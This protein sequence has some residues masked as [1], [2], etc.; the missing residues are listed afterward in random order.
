MVPRC[1]PGDLGTSV[2]IAFNGKYRIQVP[3]KPKEIAVPKPLW[4][5]APEELAMV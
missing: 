4:V 5:C 1:S 2:L 3:L